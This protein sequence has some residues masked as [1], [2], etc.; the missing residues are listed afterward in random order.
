M[1]PTSI[2]FAAVAREWWERY[3]LQGDADYAA[4]SWRQL[5][6]EAMPRLGGKP[7]RGVTAQAILAILRRVET[8][9][10]PVAARKLKSHISQIMRYGIACGHINRDPARDLGYALTPHRSRPRAAITE[11]RDIGRL[12]ADIER[13]RTGQRRCM[14]R[15]AALLF[16][17]PGELAQG[18]WC[19]VELDAGIWRIPAKKNENAASA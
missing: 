6:R 16:V 14:L 8:R 4:E 3:M 5:E 17:R 13:H 10:A 15:L 19:E 18:A 1:A 9:G 2:T 11:P 7:L 12:M